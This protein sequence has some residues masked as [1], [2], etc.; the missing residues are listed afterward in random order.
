MPIKSHIDK[1]IGAI[2]RTVTGRFT[3]Q[4]ITT[5]LDES[6]SLEEYHKNMPVIWDFSQVV[7]FQV[8]DSDLKKIANHI[9]G[10]RHERGAG[11]KSALVASPQLE[12]G[13]TRMYMEIGEELPI[14]FS[15]F[16]NIDDA[17]DWLKQA[18]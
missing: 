2:I 13:I 8:D 1:D 16:R 3:L 5:A 6:Y 7:S 14:H 11:Y 12:L 10:A 18:G 9:H 15:I 17:K 4:D